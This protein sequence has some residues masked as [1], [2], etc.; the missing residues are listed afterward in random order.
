MSHPDSTQFH[1]LLTALNNRRSV[2]A[3]QLG[4]A[5]PDEASLLRLLEAAVRVPYHG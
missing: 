2:P 5:G 4:V 3:K 1:D